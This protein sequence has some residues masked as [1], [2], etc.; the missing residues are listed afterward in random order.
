MNN[1]AKMAALILLTASL[2]LC[3]VPNVSAEGDTTYTVSVDDQESLISA[4]ET[5]NRMD[6]VGVTP[7]YTSFVLNFSGDITVD[8]TVYVSLGDAETDMDIT[9]N[10]NSH[11]LTLVDDP[12]STDHTRGIGI[13]KT[14]ESPDITVTIRSG[15]I[16]DERSFNEFDEDTIEIQGQEVGGRFTINLLG[17]EISLDRPTPGGSSYSAVAVQHA[18]VVMDEGASIVSGETDRVCG[19]SLRS[20]SENIKATVDIRNSVTIDVS[21]VPIACYDYHDNLSMSVSGKLIGDDIAISSFNCDTT[22]LEGAEL[23]GGIQIGGGTL[24]ITGGRILDDP[25]IYVED[26]WESTFS[27]TGGVFGSDISSFLGDGYALSNNTD[28]TFTVVPGYKVTFIDEGDTAGIVRVPTD[29]T[30]LK[31]D[32]PV[33]ELRDNG[34]VLIGWQTD[35]GEEFVPDGYNVKSDMTVH[36][37]WVEP[38]TELIGLIGV[39]EGNLAYSGDT[40]TLHIPGDYGAWEITWYQTGW[41]MLDA[42]SMNDAVEVGTGQS[43]DCT[44]GGTYWAV[45]VNGDET[46][47]AATGFSIV[48]PQTVFATVN[49]DTEAGSPDYESTFT[50]SL[51]IPDGWF[52]TGYTWFV[53]GMEM[54]N[55]ESF[56][57][58]ISEECE[59]SVEVVLETGYGA[60]YV[61]KGYMVIPLDGT[62]RVSFYLNN[63]NDPFYVYRV[64]P[65]TIPV[66]PDLPDVPDGYGYTVDGDIDTDEWN[67]SP[68][69]EST[70]FNI[71]QVIEDVS[72][73]L[74]VGVADDGTPQLEA[75]LNTSVEYVDSI[76][77]WTK[78]LIETYHVGWSIP[79]D[80]SGTFTVYAGIVDAEGIGGGDYATFTYTAP[81]EGGSSI[82]QEGETVSVTTDTDTA[83]ITTGSGS[84]SASMDLTFGS[85]EEGQEKVADIAIT[86][87]V[88]QGAVAVTVKPM[89]N[90]AAKSTVSNVVSEEQA[91]KAVG[92]DVKVSNVTDYRM[93]IKVPMTLDEGQYAGSAV[94][95]FIEENGSLTAVDCIVRGTE[96]WIYTTHNTKYVAVPTSIVSAPVEQEEPVF[97]DDDAGS[98]LPPFIPF[99]PQ[100]D[101]DPIEVYPSQDGGSSDGRDD[102][103]KVVAVAAAAVIAAILAIVLAS[104]YRKN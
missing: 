95:Y 17:V 64:E 83:I 91:S 12:D 4:L 87:N 3:M 6:D 100:D 51:D 71:N 27:I 7:E 68:V 45:L 46:V 5:I 102:T 48:E 104:T 42:F 21:A 47:Y 44:E 72:V 81:A 101:G 84:V 97:E 11:S 39:G 33:V 90:N 75:K 69:Y 52:V 10:L 89:G 82:G 31:E 92:V 65:G 30:I 37:V 43:I 58:Y 60:T 62:V 13:S 70:I 80:Q 28:G 22:I 86:G 38:D 8:R 63:D 85:T 18:D 35:D 99:P 1:T 79:L 59:V 98:D 94:A 77:L 2:A 16:V 41:G 96:V 73:T 25:A 53:D 36:S 78:D 19:V 57:T 14:T 54:G 40:V 24:T 50:A 56:M 66:L 23:T 93:T 88:G 74:G 67:P 76:C 34:K 20:G 32:F 15:Y 103:M 61:A 55:G 49:C 26:G 29:S 9:I